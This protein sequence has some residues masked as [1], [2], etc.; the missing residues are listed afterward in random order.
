MS[1]HLSQPG[2]AFQIGT[3]S[4]RGSCVHRAKQTTVEGQSTYNSDGLQP[5]GN[6]YYGTLQYL[7]NSL[8]DIKQTHLLGVFIQKLPA[9][10]ES[11]Q[12]IEPK[13]Y[14]H[15]IASCWAHTE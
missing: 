12:R 15:L 1:A 5:N 10:F 2:I 8:S 6:G 7:L 11:V 14:E 9:F 3:R 4:R 13:K